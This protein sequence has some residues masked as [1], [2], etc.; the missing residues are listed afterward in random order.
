M[1]RFFVCA[2]LAALGMVVGGAA[3]AESPY[4]V[5]A[6]VT[7]GEPP[8][9]SCQW[10]QAAGIQWLRVDFDWP[11]LERKPGEW[12]FTR[13]DKVMDEAERH[14]IQILP[15]LN[16]SAGAYPWQKLPYQNIDGWSDFIARVV[17][18]YGK[19]LP[20]VEIWN[21]PEAPRSPLNNPTNYLRVLRR[22]YEVVKGID[23]SIQVSICGFTGNPFKFLDE[24]YALGAKDCFDIMNIHP[25]SNPRKPEGLLEE[26]IGKIRAIMAKW[27]DA[28]KPVWISEIG[29]ETTK[30][31]AENPELLRTALAKVDAAKT[32]WRVAYIPVG[33]D[34][35]GNDDDEMIR[36][37]VLNMLN[38]LPIGSTV[39]VVAAQE[40]DAKLK[41]NAYDAVAHPFNQAYASES[42]DAVYAFVKAGGTLI[43]F[44]GAAVYFPFRQNARGGWE[45]DST[46]RS[47]RDRERLRIDLMAHWID[48]RY[49]ER[50]ALVP[51]NGAKVINIPQDRLNYERFYT[52][53]LLK[54]GDEFIPLWVGYTNGV[55]GVCAVVQK[56]NSDLKGAVVLC[57]LLTANGGS[58][59][60]DQARKIARGLGIAFADG[61]EKY[62]HFELRQLE[63]NEREQMACWGLLRSNF[64]PKPG[65]G[66]Y[67]TFIERRPAGSVQRKG[68]WKNVRTG[69]HYPQW[70]LP[71]KRKAGMLWRDDSGEILEVKFSGDKML[72]WSV[73][74]E[75]MNVPGDHGTYRIFIGESPTYFEGGEILSDFGEK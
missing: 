49:S 15:I 55:E 39:D 33:G 5:C 53:R 40:A 7:R 4:G 10:I 57:G 66:A 67:M 71:N 28:G 13:Y 36:D 54:P 44:G 32:K 63:R 72:F 38:M 64:T 16:S 19:R 43:D 61:I 41:T 12:D 42:V 48:K 26:H 37:V 9:R 24:L 8:T 17:T 2:A 73:N 58:S 74:G 23:P 68:D 3:P 27:D 18:R 29:W 56:Y 30:M 14:G 34:G 31:G 22:A 1:T 11:A 47:W 46:R 20:V 59:E 21:E 62:F 60:A 51:V 45:A 75:V 65:Y 70:T 69:L 50:M 35:N 25:Y 6:H 52:P